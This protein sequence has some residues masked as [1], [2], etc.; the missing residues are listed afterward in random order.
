MLDINIDVDS[1]NKKD[2]LLLENSIDLF[3]QELNVIFDKKTSDFY[4][5]PSKINLSRYVF[6][7]FISTNEIN[8][9]IRKYVID[10]CSSQSFYK[11][12]VQSTFL[13]TPKKVD[14]LYVIFNVYHN[15]RIYTNQYIIG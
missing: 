7:K 11:W 12:E 8:K 4:G 5:N 10:N 14:V 2:D 6:S 15:D 13:D 1:I 3:F 9:E